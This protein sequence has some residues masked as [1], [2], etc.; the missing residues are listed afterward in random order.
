MNF[1]YAIK[2]EI[3]LKDLP[4][5]ALLVLEILD[6]IENH[7]AGLRKKLMAEFKPVSN[8]VKLSLDKVA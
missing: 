5:E 4:K 7:T 6:Q 8:S 1:N 2:E 3:G